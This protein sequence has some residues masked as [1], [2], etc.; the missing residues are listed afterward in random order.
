MNREEIEK[1]LSLNYFELVDYLKAKY[2]EAKY[3]YFYNDTFRS[4]NRKVRRNKEGLFCH[5]ID[6]IKI[7]LLSDKYHASSFSFEYQKKERLVYCNYFEHLILHIKS[8]IANWST[9]GLSPLHLI[10]GSGAIYICQD[11]NGLYLNGTTLQW[12]QNSFNIIKE[13]YEEYILLLASIRLFYEEYVKEEQYR[14]TELDDQ[15]AKNKNDD[16]YLYMDWQK[17]I[18]NKV[19]DDVILRTSSDTSINWSKL[20]YAD[21]LLRGFGKIKLAKRSYWEDNAFNYLKHAY[22]DLQNAYAV[23]DIK[24]IKFKSNRSSGFI[25]CFNDGRPIF[26][27]IT[28]TGIEQTTSPDVIGISCKFALKKDG[29]PFISKDNFVDPFLRDRPRVHDKSYDVVTY[30]NGVKVTDTCKLILTKDDYIR[31]HENYEVW[32]EE[33]KNECLFE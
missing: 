7:P 17:N 31:F 27:Q 9:K 12:K 29:V 14:I 24:Q 30:D 26:Y 20:W 3:D 32:S 8:R 10:S 25:H 2:G 19:K 22:C 28:N 21:Y 16:E 1:E 11:I 23:P 33:I 18:L 15:L 13:N 5:H 4:I 6:E